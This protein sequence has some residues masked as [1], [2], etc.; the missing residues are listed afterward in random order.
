MTGRFPNCA[1]RMTQ[2]ST[3]GKTYSFGFGTDGLLYSRGTPFFTES[4]PARND[5]GLIEERNV[6]VAASVVLHE[7]PA[8]EAHS[9]LDTYT[10]QRTGEPQFT[11]D[12]Q[13]TDRYKLLSEPFAK[14]NGTLGTLQCEF[15]S[16]GLGGLGAR[17]RQ[18][19]SG[20]YDF[21]ATQQSVYGRTITETTTDASRTITGTGNA[22]GAL[23]VSLR[24]DGVSLGLAA[25]NS[26]TGNWSLPLTVQPGL[27]A[28]NA[29]ALHPSGAFT[30]AAT[31]SFTVQGAAD[32]I[33]SGYDWL[34][35]VSF[36]QRASGGRT[37][38]K[39]DAFGHLVSVSE[40][41]PTY[42]GLN[43]K[44][45]FD[46]LGRRLRVTTTPVHAN[47]ADAKAA[48]VEDSIFDPLVEFLE[49]AVAVNGQRTWKVHG[50]DLSGG[51]GGAQ[52]IGGLLATVGESNG[53][54]FGII[55]DLFG[56][57]PGWTDGTS[58]TWN[59]CR[60]GAY[61]PLPG[62]FS[63]P[64]SPD[65]P[66]R[67]GVVWRGRRVDATG[68][69]NMG[70]RFYDP[71]AG[72]F[73]STDPAGHDGSLTLYD[74][75]NGDPVNYCDPDGRFG[76]GFVGGAVDLVGGTLK[77]AG[78][79][80]GAATYGI[81]SGLDAIAGTN[82]AAYYKPA[83]D[84]WKGIG[85][86]VVSLVTSGS[87]TKIATAVA[88]GDGHSAAYYA[89]HGTFDIATLV[90]GGGLTKLSSGAKIEEQAT[91]FSEE[92]PKIHGNSLNSPKPA[93]GYSLRDRD[94]GELLK[95]GETT[96]NTARYTQKELEMNNAE[97]VFEADGT[98]LEMHQ[99]QNEKILEYKMQNGGNRPPLN[100]SD[101]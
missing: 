51:Y 18:T 39:W 34:G 94:T 96:R 95:Y 98:K 49:I 79:S 66:L 68:F 80:V 31:N 4:I 9:L 85:D 69:V 16:G 57:C 24:L 86:N 26:T 1:G 36:L 32:T 88:G 17:T 72:R 89:G 63:K 23:R 12:Y 81:A 101:W 13:Y 21:H 28:L 54:T 38:T 64:L 74:Y 97:M 30:A 90:I 91:L 100:K 61:G 71:R 84:A 42:D 48:I 62:Y 70:A 78:V 55:S 59:P 56:N 19:V 6:T 10:Y 3:D 33:G 50:P 8:W 58:V 76:K 65:T 52:G 14:S 27:H 37:D 60:V 83:F 2:V 45:V 35:N 41:S 20:S 99:W 44:A 25:L 46:G 67:E 93:E 92:V 75:A 22:F 43:Q 40:L 82:S 15:D 5:R 7:D 77:T 47:V 73:I 87:V 11:L 29:V 53:Q